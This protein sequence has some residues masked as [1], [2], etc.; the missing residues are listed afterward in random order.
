MTFEAYVNKIKRDAETVWDYEKVRDKIIFKLINTENNRELL[1]RVP[2]R[3][4]CDLSIVFMVHFGDREKGICTAMILNE[5]MAFWS[6]TA[7]DLYDAAMKNTPRLLPDTFTG[8][9]EMI[10][11]IF[12]QEECDDIIEKDAEVV[13]SL[14]YVLTNRLGIFG[15]TCLLY[16]GAVKKYANELNCDL[17]ILPSSVHETL[18]LPYDKDLNVDELREMV[19][20]VNR[21][22]VAL[23]DRLSGQVYIYQRSE[24]RISIAE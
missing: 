8:V 18:L 17:L 2:S 13:P 21:S 6:V 4:F 1:K 24:D 14:F 7:D 23:E 15:A 5:H 20:N 22:E 10:R 9:D 16:P 12:L 19:Q 11:I 3:S